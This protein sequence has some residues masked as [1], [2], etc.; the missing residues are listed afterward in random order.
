[1]TANNSNVNANFIFNSN[2]NSNSNVSVII[3][4]TTLLIYASQAANVAALLGVYSLST[5]LP[6]SR[7]LI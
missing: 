5:P 4:I 2:S 7:L 6:K 1:M 3:T